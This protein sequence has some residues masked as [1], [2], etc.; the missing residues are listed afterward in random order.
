MIERSL[1]TCARWRDD[2][3]ID[4][5]QEMTRTALSIVAAALF[6]AE[7]DDAADDIGSALTDLVDLFPRLLNP[8]ADLLLWLPIP[9][10][11]R[12]KRAV[13][14]LDRTINAIIDS[15]RSD[16][17][18]RGDLLSMLLCVR[19]AEGDALTATQLRD[20]VMTLFLTGLETVANALAWTWYQLGQ[21]PGIVSEMQREIGTGTP[22]YVRLPYTRMVFAESMRLFP[23]VW[24]ISRVALEPVT[25]GDWH[26][27]RDA[28]AVVCF[29]VTHRDARWWREPSRF[30]PLRFVQPATHPKFAYLPFGAGARGC[31]GEGFAWMEGV[32]ALA[33][34]AQRW[35][36]ESYPHAVVPQASITLRPK[37]GIRLRVRR[38]AHIGAST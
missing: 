11:R 24:A 28:L 18:D 27:P 5:H 20:E 4:V 29:A 23:P 16:A 37:G 32:L 33:T 12:L 6:G 7:V 36:L 1:R 30:D 34:I 25:V 19:D 15:R 22:E 21:N 35:H 38:R 9:K 2:E 31:I 10:T 3:V 14:R 26:V 17:D 13:E 8:L